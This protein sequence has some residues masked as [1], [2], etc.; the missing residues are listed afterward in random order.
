MLPAIFPAI[1]NTKIDICNQTVSDRQVLGILSINAS[2]AIANRK[3]VYDNMLQRIIKYTQCDNAR[4]RALPIN[5]SC[6]RKLT[7][8]ADGLGSCTLRIKTKSIVSTGCNYEMVAGLGSVGCCLKSEVWTGKA[9]I[10][11]AVSGCYISGRTGSG[12]FGD[13]FGA[14]RYSAG[15]SAAVRVGKYKLYVVAGIWA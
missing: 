13:G 3:T 10:A 14:C 15:R 5:D 1:Y 7:K 12:H 6:I 11:A 8:K 4:S 2:Y 9:A